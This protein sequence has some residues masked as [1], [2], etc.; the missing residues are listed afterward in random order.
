MS[1]MLRLV[2]RGDVYYFRT[3]VPK[4]LTGR[5]GRAEISVSL[6]TTSRPMARIRCHRISSAIEFLFDRLST[7][8]EL[9]IEEINQR[10]RSYFQRCLNAG[11]EQVNEFVADPAVD[12][13]TEIMGIQPMIEKLRADMQL[14]KFAPSIVSDAK[15]LVNP[16]IANGHSVDL[17]LVQYA[18][19]AIARAQ[20]E[21]LRVLGAKLAGD[22]HVAP[23]DPL[24]AGMM[25]NGLPP[26]PGE[27]HSQ[28]TGPLTFDRTAE[29]YLGQKKAAWAPKTLQAVEYALQL[30]SELFGPNRPITAYGTEDKKRLRDVLASLPP[31]YRKLAAFEGM[32]ANEV[33]AA[34][35]VGARLSPRSQQKTLE[36]VASF[37]QW[38][39]NEGYIEKIPGPGIK[40]I[41]AAK[42]PPGHARLPYSSAELG[43]I[44]ASPVYSGCKSRHRRS[45]P[46]KML[47]RDGYYW[48]PLIALY[49]GMRLGEIVQLRT[50]DIKEV[51]GIWV[52]DIS[53]E[54]GDQKQIKTAAS[55]R[56]VPVHSKLIE[57]GLLSHAQKS[58]AGARLF[59]DIKPGA[60][61]YMSHNFSKWWGR[62]ARQ[63]GFARKK[64][65]FHSFRHNFKDAAVSASVPELCA[66]V[67]MGHADNSV[68]AGYGSG[69]PVKRL[70]LEIDKIA[71]DIP[72]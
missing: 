41:A 60:D 17:E 28:E 63:V 31:N 4:H 45:E 38:A 22:Y 26:L 3:A 72:L 15:E 11:E 56:L 64:T 66:K 25:T 52:F 24:F 42:A 40:P 27:E 8:P 54:E 70:K 14:G 21:Q 23:N 30:A 39:L 62:Y 10:V 1:V 19:R 46:G 51:D 16:L 50:E 20:I 71:Y 58:K 32:S 2:K 69:L 37:F 68:H 43:L 34:N 33:A 5:F 55:Y 49:S 61:G 13:E 48:V 53:M 36:F 12:V 29:R 67:L 65:A 57:I 47:L 6:R 35:L 7:M 44:F 59:D 18:Q 9:T